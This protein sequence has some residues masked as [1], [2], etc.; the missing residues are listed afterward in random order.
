MNRNLRAGRQLHLRENVRDVV[1]DGFVRETEAHA[2]LFIRESF[3]HE[4]DD[5]K[6]PLG[7]QRS[8]IGPA[9]HG[10][11]MA[12]AGRRRGEGLYGRDE[13]RDGDVPEIVKDRLVHDD[14]GSICSY[15]VGHPEDRDP[16]IELE[17]PRDRAADSRINTHYIN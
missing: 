7:E 13:V 9:R 17:Q 6:F 2:D 10:L 11:K 8:H 5:L 12:S 4:L 16:R 3:G 15:G 14:V 1:L